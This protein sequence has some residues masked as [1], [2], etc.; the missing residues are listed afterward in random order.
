MGALSREMEVVKI[1]HHNHKKFSPGHRWCAG[2]SAGPRDLYMTCHWRPWLCCCCIHIDGAVTWVQRCEFRVTVSSL[3]TFWVHAAVEGVDDRSH[4]FMFRRSLHICQENQH[5]FSPAGK[6]RVVIVPQMKS[7]TCYVHSSTVH[8][9]CVVHVYVDQP[10]RQL[11]LTNKSNTFI[12]TKN[13]HIW[14]CIF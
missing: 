1:V 7:S 2:P 5:I 4:A 14:V 8:I 13:L 9:H 11:C 3:M 10:W 6:Y 12:K